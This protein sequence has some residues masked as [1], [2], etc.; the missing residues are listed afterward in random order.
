ML[1]DTTKRLLT[2]KTFDAVDRIVGGLERK[3]NCNS[4]EK[5]AIAIHEAGHATVSWMLEHAAPLIKVTIVPRTK[6]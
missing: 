6:S 3:Q 4:G 5:K 1:P 2:N